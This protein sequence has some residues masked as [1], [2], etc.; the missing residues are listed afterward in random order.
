M[1]LDGYDMM[2]EHRRGD[3]HQNAHNLSK[4]TEI[5]EIQAQRMVSKMV[6]RLWT[7]DV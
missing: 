4:K 6:S 2:I 5:Y 3:K 1:H 7:R